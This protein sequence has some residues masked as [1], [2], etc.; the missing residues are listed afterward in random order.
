M[1]V[2]S[3]NGARAVGGRKGVGL[4]AEEQAAVRKTVIEPANRPTLR[5]TEMFRLDMVRIIPLPLFLNT[6]MLFGSG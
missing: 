5:K 6:A 4:E 2:G 3:I 1:K